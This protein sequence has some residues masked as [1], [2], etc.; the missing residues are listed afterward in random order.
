MLS[1]DIG[2]QRY[3]VFFEPANHSITFCVFIDEKGFTHNEC[4]IFH[5][6]LCH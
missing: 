2:L 6:P 1:N 3:E 4:P 5:I